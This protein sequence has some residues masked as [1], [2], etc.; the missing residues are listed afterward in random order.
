MP[1]SRRAGSRGQAAPRGGSRQTRSAAAGRTPAA[2]SAPPSMRPTGILL[3]FVSCG[4]ISLALGLVWRLTL[5]PKRIGVGSALLGI[6]LL[7]SGFVAGGVLWYIRDARLRLRDPSRVDDERIIFSFVVFVLMP[8]VVLAV[9]GMV[10]LVA[11]IIGG[12]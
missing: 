1:A 6:V 12:T 8:F 7:L 10:W 4:L 3:R 9:V 5:A 11:L 2:P